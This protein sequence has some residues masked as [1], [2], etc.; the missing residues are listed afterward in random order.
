[1]DFPSGFD[2]SAYERAKTMQDIL[3]A[4]CEGN[5]THNH[6]YEQLRRE[7]MDQ[8]VLKDLLPPFVRTGQDL[9]IFWGWIKGQS[10]KWEPRHAA[11]AVNL[12][13]SMANFLIETL[14]ARKRDGS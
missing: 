12:A 3:V 11:L 13:G 6:T 10:D 9:D 14:A 1:M 5:R 4:A 8:P 7:F 2:M